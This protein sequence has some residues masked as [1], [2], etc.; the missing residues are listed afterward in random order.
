MASYS[1]LVIALAV[2]V[3]VFLDYLVAIIDLFEVRL[4]KEVP[5]LSS[6]VLSPAPPPRLT[7]FTLEICL[8]LT[9][10]RIFPTPPSTFPF[11]LAW[12][13]HSSSSAPQIQ[14][15]S[16]RILQSSIRLRPRPYPQSI[17]TSIGVK[18]LQDPLSS[19]GS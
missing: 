12:I 15:E 4:N 5:L 10:I 7:S 1:E 16:H 2:I 19:T 18:S 3:V 13:P 8:F 14:D 6:A 17:T 9:R 11:P